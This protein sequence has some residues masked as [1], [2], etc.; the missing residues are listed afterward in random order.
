MAVGQNALTSYNS[1]ITLARET[2]LGTYVTG[3]AA[4]DF[5]SSS[6]KTTLDRK[7]IEQIETKRS[8]S[9]QVALSKK[10]EG[11]IEAYAY[12]ESTAFVYLLQNAL[13]GA[14]TSATTT[15]ET[16]GSASFEHTILFGNL[17]EQTNKGLS[18]NMRKG[19]SSGAGAVWQY[20]GGRVDELSFSAE[21]DEALKFSASLKFFD[22]T[23]TTNDVASTIA[24]NQNEPLSFVSGRVSVEGTFASL[25]STSFWHVQSVEFGIQNNLKADKESRRIGSNALQVLPQGMGSFPLSMTMRYDTTTALDAMLASTQLAVELEFTGSTLTG[26]KFQRSLKFQFPKVMVM[27]ADPEIGGPDEVLTSQ[28]QFM[29]LRDSLGGYPMRAIV[30]NLTSSY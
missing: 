25:T 8:Y 18:V 26:S 15:G 14:L 23:K 5:I 22:S 21:I 12:A 28:V 19:D 1:Y 4:L 10:V 7:I 30:R 13:G 11:E 16:T 29:V 27:D 17:S 24:D 2:A 9:K 6:L 20:N 3:T